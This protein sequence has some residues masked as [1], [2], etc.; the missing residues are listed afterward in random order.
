MWSGFWF[1][2]VSMTTVGYGDK[3]PRSVGGRLVTLV[4]MFA[5]IILISFFTA[6]IATALT[7]QSLE[8]RVRGP[9]DLARVRVA[10]VAG[11]TSAAYLESRDVPFTSLPDAEAA[12]AELARGRADA[13]VYDRP[14]LRWLVRKRGDSSLDVLHET[15]ERQDYAFVLPPDSPIR[16][17]V[18]RALLAELQS[19]HWQRLV[20]QY[21]GR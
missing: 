11:T 21:L 3:A 18:N 15:F 13:V 4:W 17:D 12:V 14:I 1:A 16:E 19:D 7:V 10:S 6:A 8:T 9:E 20:E 5:S 2:A